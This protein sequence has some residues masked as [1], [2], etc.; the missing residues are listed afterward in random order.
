MIKEKKGLDEKKNQTR[1]I[2]NKNPTNGV[3]EKKIRQRGMNTP[4]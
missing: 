4:I 3:L 2:N 1:I